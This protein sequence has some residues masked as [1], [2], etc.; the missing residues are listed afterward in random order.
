MPFPWISFLLAL[1]APAAGD[2]SQDLAQLSLRD[3]MRMRVSDVNVPGVYHVH[4]PGEAMIGL[5]LGAMRMDGLR[6]GTSSVDT[7]TALGTYPVAP[8]EMD[9]QHAMLHVMYGWSGRLT[10]AA[11]LPWSSRS[12]EHATGMGGMF[13]T[14]SQGVGDLRVSGLWSLLERDERQLFADLGV[15]LPTGSIDARDQTPMS[16]GNEVRLPY[17][18][19]LGS[20]TWDVLPALTWLEQRGD[21]NYGARAGAVLRTG[22]NDNDYRLGD[23]WNATAWASRLVGHNTSLSLRLAG[24]TWDDVHGADPQLMPSVSPAADPD[25]QAGSRLDLHLGLNVFDFGPGD[26]LRALLEVGV[27]VWQDLDGPQLETDLLLAFGLE[28]RH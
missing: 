6:D 16:G 25:L 23:R 28:W 10:L 3:L 12:M 20:G 4:A 9:M 5:S 1:P 15:S 19:Q 7:A 8:L 26:S 11:M 13:T 27:P 21:W 18:M 24:S 17:P 2:P 14:R 22:R